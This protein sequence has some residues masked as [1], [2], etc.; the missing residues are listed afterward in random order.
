MGEAFQGKREY[1]RNSKRYKNITKKLAVFGGSSNTPNSIVENVEFQQLI[2][3]LDPRYPFPSRALLDKELDKVLVDL[4][5]SIYTYLAAA[6]KVYKLVCRYL[7]KKAMTS[8]YLEV[9]AHFFSCHDHWKHCVTL[10]VRRL[11]GCHTAEH[12]KEVVEELMKEWEIPESKVRVIVTDNGSNMVAVFKSHFEE[13]EMDV[14]GDIDEDEDDFVSKEPDHD[15][16][17]SSFI[18]INVFPVSLT[19]SSWLLENLINYPS[20]RV[21]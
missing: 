15:I 7:V 19:L 4:K 8:S 21:F 1:N 18:K 11:L 13:E 16:T 14:D 20:L 3:S 17:F 10:A 2:K 12:V 6:R 9:T 5:A